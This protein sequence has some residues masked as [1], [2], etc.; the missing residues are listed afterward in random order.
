MLFISLAVIFLI[1]S[2]QKDIITLTPGNV[3]TEGEG[4]IGP[5]GGLVMIDDET[6]PLNGAFVE[7]PEGA[8][9][10]D[11][12]IKISQVPAEVDNLADSLATL[13]KFEPQGLV[14]ETPITIGIPVHIN[15]EDTAGLHI[16][17]FEPDSVIYTQI[18]KSRID[19]DKGIIIGETMHFSYY[20]AIDKRAK[21]DIEMLTIDSRIG[22]RLKLKDLDKIRTRTS[23]CLNDGYC[24]VWEV[25]RYHTYYDLSVFNVSLYR[26]RSMWLDDRIE[27]KN[28]YVWRQAHGHSANAVVLI[29]Y[30]GPEYDEEVYRTSNIS[31]NGP[32][33]ELALWNSG[34]PLVFYFDDFEPNSGH[35][36]YVKVKWFY[37]PK[38]WLKPCN[39]LQVL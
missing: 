5:K 18:P 39:L 9:K 13:V 7:I 29:G 23:V 2:C 12:L 15:N 33:S 27:S 11:T 32:N 17:H 6:S 8:L 22:A 30:D 28:I 3:Y 21:I 1:K 14:F 37:Y 10:T 25:I 24:N 35:N 31:Q 16:F 20:T 4:S 34:E 26:H 19:L 36:Y 38:H